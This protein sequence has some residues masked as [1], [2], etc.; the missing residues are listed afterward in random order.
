MADEQTTR[1]LV[2]T[3]LDIYANFTDHVSR[4][5]AI[6]TWTSQLE[7]AAKSELAALEAA[8]R[9]ALDREP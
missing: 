8:L 1:A 2:S 9:E 6:D 7:A 5:V 3:M 4:D